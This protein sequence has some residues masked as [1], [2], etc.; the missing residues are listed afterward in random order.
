MCNI[1]P[2][3][4]PR[5]CSATCPFPVSVL[6][7]WLCLGDGDEVLGMVS[8]RHGRGQVDKLAAICIGSSSTLRWDSGVSI[9]ETF[10]CTAMVGDH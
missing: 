7:H 8:S 4:P 1:F 6:W 9:F 5:E 3:P 2:F 10:Q